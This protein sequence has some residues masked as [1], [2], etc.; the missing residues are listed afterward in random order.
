MGVS[1]TAKAVSVSQR[2]TEAAGVED[3]RLQP[4]LVQAPRPRSQ[5]TQR[6]EAGS[7]TGA[8]WRR[9]AVTVW[10]KGTW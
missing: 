4:E 6:T 3:T 8:R 5:A 7:V 9:L 10:G 1:I 2:H